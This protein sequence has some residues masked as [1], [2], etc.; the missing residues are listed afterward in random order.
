M[1]QVKHFSYQSPSHS[2]DTFYEDSGH[3][4]LSSHLHSIKSDVMSMGH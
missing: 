1:Q 4:H 2:Y 3:I